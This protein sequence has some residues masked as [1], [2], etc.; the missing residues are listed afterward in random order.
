MASTRCWIRT[1]DVREMLGEGIE[2]HEVTKQY[3][4]NSG[5]VNA[6]R[7]IDIRIARGQIFAL[8]GHNGA[9]KSTTISI[10]TGQTPITAGE[11]TIFGLNI[12]EPGV[13]DALRMQTGVCPQHNILYEQLNVVE[14]LQLFAEIKCLPR[15]H[16]AALIDSLIVELDLDE[17]RS[18]LSN[19]LSGG[20]KRKV[21]VAIAMLG[22]S[23]LIFLGSFVCLFVLVRFCTCADDQTNVPRAW[24][25]S[26]AAKCLSC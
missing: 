11:A 23:K 1:N 10:L 6:L 22:D 2:L 4:G 8:L 26:L 3:R 18:K 19:S 12:S 17:H 16:S 13:I 14:H 24:T 9:G 5:K 21:C 15:Q 7:G 25:R 20:M